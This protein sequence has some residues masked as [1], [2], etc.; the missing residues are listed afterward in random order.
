M[1]IPGPPEYPKQW[2]I[3]STLCIGYQGHH[4]GGLGTSLK[5]SCFSGPAMT[6]RSS[7][8]AAMTQVSAQ[9]KTFGRLCL[10]DFQKEVCKQEASED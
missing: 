7:C 4:F 10:L 6:D 5:Q 9:M 2:P 3:Y 1:G 8:L